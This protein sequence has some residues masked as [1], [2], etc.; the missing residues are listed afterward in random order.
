M[1]KCKNLNHDCTDVNVA[2]NEIYENVRLFLSAD[3]PHYYAT[4][5]DITPSP[6]LKGEDF[7]LITILHQDSANLVALS[8]KCPKMLSSI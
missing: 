7:F 3:L 2:M 8:E 5:L 4:L 1:D 6:P